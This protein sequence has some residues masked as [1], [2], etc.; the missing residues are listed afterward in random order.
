VIPSLRA[1]AGALGLSLVIASMTP[2]P[3]GA[4]VAPTAGIVRLLPS[5]TS[6]FADKLRLA[7]AT[8]PAGRFPVEARPGVTSWTTAGA[9]HWAA[10]FVP[11]QLWEL[12]R[13]TGDVEWRRLAEAMDTTLPREARD[14][15]THDLGFLLCSPYV[16]AYESTKDSK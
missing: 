13:A 2:G 5:P 3:A 15:H 9:W 12:Y 10:G 8:T 14:T 7:A 4:A 6:V 16:P 11:G 1:V